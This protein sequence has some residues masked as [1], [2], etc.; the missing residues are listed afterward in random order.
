MNQAYL[1]MP[2]DT[3][4][5]IISRISDFIVGSEIFDVSFMKWHVKGND[6]SPKK[7]LDSDIVFIYLPEFAIHNDNDLYGYLGK[8]Q[9]SELE[10]VFHRD[11]E[12]FFINDKCELFLTEHFTVNDYND[13][14][15]KYGKAWLTSVTPELHNVPS[16]KRNLL[17]LLVD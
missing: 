9:F 4:Q 16:L 11:K 2:L 7:L 13:W 6:Y 1:S 3:P 8:G 10:T 12:Y 5:S 14:K 17:L 15:R